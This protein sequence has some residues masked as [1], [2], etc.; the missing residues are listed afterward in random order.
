M[1]L[2][3][4]ELSE[5]GVGDKPYFTESERGDVAF[6]RS[7]GQWAEVWGHTARMA[8]HWEPPKT[9]G[10]TGLTSNAHRFTM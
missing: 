6:P 1:V 2:P 10:G 8:D 5:L 3:V 4:P 7:W 9:K